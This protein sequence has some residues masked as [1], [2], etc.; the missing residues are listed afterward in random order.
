MLRTKDKVV[1]MKCREI[2]IILLLPVVESRSTS[3]ESI[4]Y[5]QLEVSWWLDAV[6]LPS[7]SAFCSL[8][9]LCADDSLAVLGRTGTALNTNAETLQLQWSIIMIGALSEIDGDVAS[10]Q[11]TIQVATRSLLFQRNPIPFARFIASLSKSPESAGVLTTQSSSPLVQYARS[12]VEYNETPSKKRL[13]Q[14]TSLLECA[15]SPRHEFCKVLGSFL[16][17]RRLDDTLYHTSFQ[18]AM[19]LARFS[20][21]VQLISPELDRIHESCSELLRRTIP[22][23]SVRM[24][25]CSCSSFPSWM[26]L[27]LGTPFLS[28]IV[29][30]ISEYRCHR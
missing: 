4:A 15:F 24:S 25:Q 1:H 11:M 21:H 30:I 16:S 6:T 7:L 29:K 26:I 19:E 28:A 23:V 10:Y 5:F 27:T 17:E 14:L 22:A 20:I 18:T 12:L 8:I 9:S 2:A 13:D 3:E